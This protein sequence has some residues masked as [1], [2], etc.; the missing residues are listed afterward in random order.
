MSKKFSCGIDENLVPNWHRKR[1]ENGPLS[2]TQYCT[3]TDI[4]KKHILNKNVRENVACGQE[5]INEKAPQKNFAIKDKQQK[6]N[7]YCV[8]S[9]VAQ[10]KQQILP[11]R[12]YFATNEYVQIRSQTSKLFESNTKCEKFMQ[13]GFSP[14]EGWRE[15]GC[16]Q[17]DL[18]SENRKIS[19]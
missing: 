12:R 4:E 16:C 19:Q 18:N 5:S 10:W 13:Q 1:D 2:Y 3:W 14:F 11:K 9:E 7:R 6:E 15:C 17:I 8:Y